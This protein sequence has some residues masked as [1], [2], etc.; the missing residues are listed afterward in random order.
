M[1]VLLFSFAFDVWIG[2]S[3]ESKITLN[4]PENEVA[5]TIAIYTTLLVP[6][7]KYALMV[8][9]VA[10]AI[11]AGR[12]S[13]NHRNRTPVKLFIGVALLLN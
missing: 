1:Q 9:P 3:V 12:I 6:V 11:E 10:I 5:A 8:T 4:L 2:E 7:T 13:E